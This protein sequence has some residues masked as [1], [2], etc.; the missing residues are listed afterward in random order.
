MGNLNLSQKLL[1]ISLGG[2]GAVAAIAIICFSLLSG[3]VKEY[4]ETL[5]NDVQAATIAN[6]MTILFK[7]QVQE[8]KNTLL[9]GEDD[10][11]RDKYWGR[12]Q[13]RQEEIQG[14][15][16][17][18]LAMN[19]PPAAKEQVE[20]FMASHAGLPAKYQL[21][22]DAYME[23]GFDHKA[24][25]KAV[26]GIDRAPTKQ[27]DEAANLLNENTLVKSNNLH[28]SG[29]ATALYGMIS[30]VIAVLLVAAASFFVI[31]KKV[32][33]PLQSMIRLLRRLADGDYSNEIEVR[34]ADEI[35]EM[36]KAIN[37]LKNKL[38]KTIEGL[39]DALTV[40]NSVSTGMHEASRDISNGTQEQY[41]RTD[42]VATAMTEMSSTAQEVADHANNAAQ[43]TG[44][45][46]DTAKS[47]LGVMNSAIATITDMSHHIASTT[48]VIKRL[49]ENANQV[50]TVLDVIKGIAEQT[51]LL[52]LNAAIEAARAGEQGRGFAVVADEVRTLAQRTQE[53]TAEIHGIIESVQHAA[54]DAVKAIEQ[55][56][57]QSEDSVGKVTESGDTLQAIETAVEQLTQMNHQIASA[58]QEQTHVAEDITRHITEISEFA[59]RNNVEAEKIE[60]QSGQLVNIKNDFERLMANLKQ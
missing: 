3:K 39:A 44:D 12:F 17:E 33:A 35:G 22:Y 43:A 30:I 50:G 51:N 11:K 45:A 37:N 14:M 7:I 21:G 54:Q 38:E 55:G 34:S 2:I 32:T 24:G 42:Q 31:T 8:W 28:D 49:E 41:S 29:L 5:N 9:R 48:N 18:L 46:D 59:N 25:D 27:I 23:S 15:G 20:L 26:S 10:A 57:T 58:A 40:L 6:K 53:S 36:A 47:A 13:K 4:D 52:A 56:K 60:S 16:R 19:L 1:G